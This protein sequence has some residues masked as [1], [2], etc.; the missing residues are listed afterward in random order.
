MNQSSQSDSSSAAPSST[1]K[2]Y[3]AKPHNS[4]G[5]LW[6]GLRA[7]IL[8]QSGQSLRASIED[9]IEQHD[10][11]NVDDVTAEE[12]FMLRN[13]LEFGSQRIEDVMVPR[14]DII[15]VEDTTTLAELFAVFLEANHSRIPVYRETLDEPLGMVHVKDLA[16]WIAETAKQKKTKRKSSQ[17]APKKAPATEMVPNLAGADL[18]TTIADAKIMREM[19]FVPPSM[20]AVDLLVKMQSSQI[21]LALVV[22]E[23]GGTDGLVSIEDLVEEI[24]GEIADEHDDPDAPMIVRQA[25]GTLIT[26]ARAQIE[27]LEQLV[28]VDLMPDEDEDDADT[29]GGLVFTLVGRVPVRGELIRHSSGLQFEVLEGD[30]RRL[31]KLRVHTKPV[32]KKEAAAQVRKAK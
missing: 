29:L 4:L 27:D 24:V 2:G 20:P 22:D 21:H 1:G 17:A 11:G 30:P 19:L 32:A 28:D 16:K 10:T 6:S 31:K 3:G 26:D 15:A 23:Y 12:R 9:V 5:Q 25:D 13:I 8:G 7:K 14:A 18:S